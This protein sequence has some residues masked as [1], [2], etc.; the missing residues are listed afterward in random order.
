MD[1]WNKHI[2]STLEGYPTIEA[3]IASWKVNWPLMDCYF[4]HDQAS[5]IAAIQQGMAL[6]CYD[7]SYQPYLS[8]KIGT[9]ALKIEDPTTRT[10]MGGSVPCSR[11]EREI[12]SCRAEL[13]GFH[14]L[15]M[16]L[17]AFCLFH[18]ITKGQV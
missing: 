6:G 13:Q 11:T 12:G 1:P 10:S 2:P 9:A 15:L 3:L 16:G 18:G 8:S 5:L 4:P 14:T 17:K 7:G